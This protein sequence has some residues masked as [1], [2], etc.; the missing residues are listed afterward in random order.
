[1]QKLNNE[2]RQAC[3]VLHRGGVI[4]YPTDTVWGIGCD[5]TRPEAVDR[6]R[7]IKQR[8]EQQPMIVLLGTAASLNYYVKDFPEIALELVELSEQPLTIVYPE[9]RN[10]A[11]NLAATDGSIGI[12]I[13]RERFSAGLCRSFKK[14]VVSTSANIA[15][16]A[17]PRCFSEISPEI[18]QAVDHIVDYRREDISPSAPSAIIK[19][20]K[21]AQVAIIRQ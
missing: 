13:T 11:P 9:A 7:A 2:I 14:P 16:A 19:L 20:G 18:L 5:A 12:R 3:D 15:G 4:L 10:L 1:M 6:I 21:N 17:F 8:P